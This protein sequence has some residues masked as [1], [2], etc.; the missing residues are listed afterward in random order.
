MADGEGVSIAPP[1]MIYNFETDCRVAKVYFAA[2]MFEELPW[3]GDLYDK[4]L[5]AIECIPAEFMERN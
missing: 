3:A 5:L 1:G 4:G 2:S